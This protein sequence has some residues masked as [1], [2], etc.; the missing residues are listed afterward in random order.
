VFTVLLQTVM[1]VFQQ[2][3]SKWKDQWG[4]LYSREIY[5]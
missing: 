1:I 4:E 2:I 3:T 5:R